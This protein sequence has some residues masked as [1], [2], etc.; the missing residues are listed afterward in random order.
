MYVVGRLREFYSINQQPVHTK[1]EGNGQKIPKF[2][3]HTLWT[4]HNVAVG[5]RNDRRKEAG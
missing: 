4:P 2:C 3:V 1:G 5:R